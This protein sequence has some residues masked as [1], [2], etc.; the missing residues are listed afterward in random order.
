VYAV[1]G[2]RR[3][4][5]SR[6]FF[7]L[8]SDKGATWSRSRQIDDIPA[9][10]SVD[11]FMPAVA[12]NRDG[13]I[14][15]I[16]YDRRAHSDNM[17][18]DVRFAASADGGKTFTPSVRV[19]TNGMTF[20]GRNTFAA[21][22]GSSVR[23]KNSAEPG[24]S[25]DLSLN[26]FTFLG[27]DTDGLAA[28]AN[29]AFHPLWVDNRTGVPQVWTAVVSVGDSAI[30]GGREVSDKIAVDIVDGSFDQATGTITAK[31][32]LRNSTT[33]PVSGPFSIRIRDARSEFG[34]VLLD[35][36]DIVF[37]ERTLAPAGKSTTVTMKFRLVNPQPFR[38]GNRYK[39]G[40]LRLS[41]QVLKR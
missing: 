13:V 34:D 15:V 21:L 22:R 5:N 11:N 27:G 32:Q 28:D 36:T 20:T 18:W 24:V 37:P 30:Y 17:G 10:D 7:A 16:W 29:G 41:A 14:G 25:I 8:S 1:W 23:T 38:S 35:G 33:S 3:T 39:V 9:T 4:G 19:S 6:I 40:L 12:V 31:V 26:T 2:D